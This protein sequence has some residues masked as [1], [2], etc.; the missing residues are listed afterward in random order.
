M[1]VGYVRQLCEGLWTFEE[2]I[3]NPEFRRRVDHGRYAMPLDE[4]EQCTGR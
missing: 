1:R 2:V 3:S 4:I